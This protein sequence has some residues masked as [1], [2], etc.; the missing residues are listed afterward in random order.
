MQHNFDNLVKNYRYKVSTG[1]GKTMVVN[2]IHKKKSKHLVYSLCTQVQIVFLNNFRQK[3]KLRTT[4]IY[5]NLN[6]FTF[7]IVIIFFYI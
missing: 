1:V 2:F 4:S 6:K 5:L 3:R 7:H